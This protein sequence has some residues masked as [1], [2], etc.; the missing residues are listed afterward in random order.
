MKYIPINELCVCFHSDAGFGNAKANSTQAGYVAAFSNIK[1]ADNESSVWSPF[2]WKSYK[3]P[4][5]VAST[6]AGE[7]QAYATAAAVSEWM[8]LML[9]EAIGGQFDLRSSSH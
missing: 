9:A 3:L 4:R 8:A 1:L 2:A 7:S 5:K 6:L